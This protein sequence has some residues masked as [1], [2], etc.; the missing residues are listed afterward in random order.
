MRQSSRCT[1]K[2]NWKLLRPCTIQ[3]AFLVLMF[4]S[5]LLAAQ[6]QV[7]QQLPF[8][9]DWR[10]KKGDPNQGSTSLFY[11]LS[12][13]ATGRNASV[14]TG[15]TRLKED[16]GRAAQTGLKPWILP[17]GND[18]I[19]APARRHVRPDGN[20]GGEC[21]YVQV[22]FDDG[23]WERVN[24]PHD[25][26]IKGPFHVGWGKGVGGGMGRL[27][28]PGIGW[29]RKKFT[30][31]ASD[32]AKSIFLDIDG[33]MSYAVVWLNGQ[34]VGGWP[35][36]YASWRV[37][38]TPYAVPGGENQLAI[39]LD[40]PPESSRWYP[41]G[42]IYRNV[43]LVKTDP[44]HVGQWGTFVTTR[45]VSPASATIDLEVTIDNDSKTDTIAKA[46]TLVFVLDA[47]GNK[48][49]DAIAGFEPLNVSSKTPAY[50]DHHP[51][52]LPTVMQ[53]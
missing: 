28:S 53:R 19:K 29:Y 51:H 47:K 14:S 13:E 15:V 46:I 7:R 40:N 20:P 11:D 10:F 48:T 32:A 1:E 9:A 41:G 44:V 35:Y 4:E 2:R 49:G 43:W 30:I 31:P 21:P 38:L 23:P 17:T 34:L 24:L 8:N 5:M 26:A 12:M 16:A 18:F 25:W 50:G 3:C 39:R 37:D 33:A 42:G 45:D 22:D 27:P 36:G 6:S 52:R